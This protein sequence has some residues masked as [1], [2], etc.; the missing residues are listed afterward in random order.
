MRLIVADADA[1][2][3]W[4]SLLTDDSG[5]LIAEHAV[6]FDAGSWQ[7]RAFADLSGYLSWQVEPDRLGE[8]RAAEIVGELGAW[9]SEV[10]LGP[11]TRVFVRE[12]PVTV[13]VEVPD[14]AEWLLMRPWELAHVDGKPLAVRGVTFVMRPPGAPAARPTDGVVSGRLRVLGLFSL[15]DRDQPLALRRE[16]VTLVRQIVGTGK[17]ADV[18]VL[19]YGVTRDRLTKL[20]TEPSGW[21]IIH[22]SGHGAPGELLLENA[23]GTPDPVS[24][25]DL[26]GLLA[27]VRGRVRL[28]TLATCWSAA[29]ATAEQRRLLNL[30]ALRLVSPA[31]PPS[32]RQTAALATELTRRLDCAVLAMRYPVADEF[33]IRLSGSVYELLAVSGEPLPRAVGRALGNLS[34]GSGDGSFHALSYATPALFGERA[35]GLAFSVPDRGTADAVGTADPL[36]SRFP[37]PPARFVGRTAVMARASAALAADSRIPG[38]LLHGM[39]GGGKTAAALELAHCLAHTFDRMVWFKAPDEGTETGNALTD[40]ALTLDPYLDGRHLSPMVADTGQLASF[41][42][43]LTRLMERERLLLVIDNVESLLTATGEWRDP[44][45]AMVARALTAHTGRGRVILTSRR[46]PAELKDSEHD[47]DSDRKPRLKT[48][49]VD[50]LSVNEALMLAA[51]LPHLGALGRGEIP[52]ISRPTAWKLL[53]DVLEIAYGLPK[54]L[55]LADGQAADRD[56]L[57]AL[58]TTAHQALGV[59]RGR[60]DSFL[61]EGGTAA[62]TEDYVTVL[63][64]W[65]QVVAGTLKDGTRGMFCLLCCLEEPDRERSVVGAVWPGLRHEPAHVGEIPDVDSMLASIAGSGLAAVRE[66]SGPGGALYAIHPAVAAAGRQLAGDQFRDL[67][68]AEAAAYWDAAY[69]RA[70]GHADQ[71]GAD[72]GVDTGQV[73]RAGLAA[74]SYLERQG[75]WASAAAM[76]YEAIIRAPTRAN[77]AALLPAIERIA[78]EAPVQEAVLARVLQEL[79]SAVT[80]ETMRTSME[81]AVARRDYQAASVTATQLISRSLNGGR[82]DQA[83]RYSVEALEYTR[84]NGSGP[85]TQLFDESMRLQVLTRLGE[86]ERV[87]REVEDLR[88]TMETLPAVAGPD[89]ATVNPWNAREA[90]F[91]V[92]RDAAERL[93]RW[94]EALAMNAEVV[95]S[96][97]GRAAPADAVARSRFNDYLPLLGLGRGEEARQLLSDCRECF[98]DVGNLRMLGRTLGALASVEEADGRR[99]AA[100]RLERHALEY[101][102]IANDVRGIAVSYEHLGTYAGPPAAL[103]CHLAAAL[104]RALTSPEAPRSLTQVAAALAERDSVQPADVTGLARQLGDIPGNNLAGLIEALPVS[105]AEANL[106]LRNLIDQAKDQTRRAGSAHDQGDYLTSEEDRT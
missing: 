41:L 21:D 56:R 97:R 23:D 52:G 30:P 67:V 3:S 76:V 36:T 31:E 37:P 92:G 60:P 102:Y 43:V 33:A 8:Q 100:I 57:T 89:D 101:K 65:T 15:P 17:A 104:I 18:H 4:R 105:M 70:S 94:E 78:K 54:L 5:T 58:V 19:Q 62:S 2:S 48:E 25:A 64:A 68:D 51:E 103:A 24:A 26:A 55:E 90:L 13:R 28:V 83:L 27:A 16:R 73:V 12:A 95:A 87:L 84:L 39:P 14:G 96:K 98:Q 79:D 53:H 40:F 42:P 45:W 7:A 11:F 66:S 77:A 81:A 74:V 69:R 10:V 32:A 75:Q 46:V 49:L 59:R 91:S 99:D 85:W 22:L 44:R 93:C 9:I 1:P 106:T 63:R 80:E 35:A 34:A 61:A 82:L 6:D 47:P 50:V 86:A 29:D 38:V 72:G 20:L 88:D 71:T